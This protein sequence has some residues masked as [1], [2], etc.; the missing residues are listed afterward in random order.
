MRFIPL[1]LEQLKSIDPASVD[2]DTLTDIT[3]VEIDRNKPHLEQVAD[4]LR[5]IR[6]PYLYRCGKVVVQ[7]AYKEGTT[8]TIEDQLEHLIREKHYAESVKY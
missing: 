4:F 3:Q 7:V 5:Q 1:E 8:L 6:N 2:R